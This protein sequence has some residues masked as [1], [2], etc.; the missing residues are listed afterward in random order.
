MIDFTRCRAA[1]VALALAAAAP[2]LAQVIYKSTMP[3]G[4]VIYG[5]APVPGAIKSE[6]TNV[7]KNS[8]VTPVTPT[9]QQPG[10]EVRRK[11]RQS[12]ADAAR[13]ELQAAEQALAEAQ[14]ARQAGREPLEGER[15]GTAGGGNRLSE[16]YFQR[17][18]ALET[19]VEQAQQRVE[20]ARVLLRQAQ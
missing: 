2:A 17:Q 20:A 9:Q 3:D 7:P 8:G 19:A 13:V 18:Q 6:P 10:A 11:E 16:S 1:V 14:A 12:A 4:R 15:Q 5:D